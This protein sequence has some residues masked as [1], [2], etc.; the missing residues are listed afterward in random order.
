MCAMYVGAACTLYL[1]LK[2]G[3]VT[4]QRS[5][6]GTSVA[7]SIVNILS[8]CASVSDANAKAKKMLKGSLC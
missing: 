7:A 3:G 6:M 8:L 2:L 1:Q 5:K 4:F